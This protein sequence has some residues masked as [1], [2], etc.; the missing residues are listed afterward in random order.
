VAHVVA[1]RSKRTGDAARDERL[2]DLLRRAAPRDALEPIP[3]AYHTRTGRQTLGGAIDSQRGDRNLFLQYLSEHRDYVLRSFPQDVQANMVD[4][5]DSAPQHG[6]TDIT[7]N[8]KSFIHDWVVRH[9]GIRGAVFLPPSQPDYNPTELLFSFIKGVIRRRFPPHVGEVPVAEMVRLIDGAF[10]EVTKTMVEGWLRYGCYRVPGDPEA[11]CGARTRDRCG[12]SAT[13]HV[14]EWWTR[15]LHRWEETN[16]VLDAA[17]RHDL[18]APELATPELRDRF[19][20]AR[21]LLCT[22]FRAVRDVF[23]AAERP[24]AHV[25]VGPRGYQTRVAL[26]SDAA[27]LDMPLRTQDAVHVTYADDT[28]TEHSDN[29]KSAALEELD[30]RVLRLRDD[31]TGF[32]VLHAYTERIQRVSARTRAALDELEELRSERAG[33]LA[34]LARARDGAFAVGAVVSRLVERS[35]AI[36][37]QDVLLDVQECVFQPKLD[38]RHPRT[39]VRV[40]L[41]GESQRREWRLHRADRPNPSRRTLP[42][43]CVLVAAAS[44]VAADDQEYTVRAVDA[45]V[46][47]LTHAA[48][49]ATLEF[50]NRRVIDATLASLADPGTARAAMDEGARAAEAE[51]SRT[52]YR[53]SLPDPRAPARACAVAVIALAAYGHERERMDRILVDV[54]ARYRPTLGDADAR[55]AAALEEAVRVWRRRRAEAGL[56]AAADGERDGSELVARAESL[57]P[58]FVV[59]H[60]RAERRAKVQLR[61][62]ARGEDDE[63]RYPGYPLEEQDGRGGKAYTVGAVAAGGTLTLPVQ[64]VHVRA[65]AVDVRSRREYI[66]G[67]VVFEDESRVE[68]G[69]PLL[70]S[71]RWRVGNV[72]DEEFVRKNAV[73]TGAGDEV[74]ENY[75]NIDLRAYDQV[76]QRI[77]GGISQQNANLLKLARDRHRDRLAKSGERTVAQVRDAVVGTIGE[78]PLRFVG[79]EAARYVRTPDHLLFDPTR[80]SLHAPIHE[81]AKHVLENGRTYRE[82]GVADKEVLHRRVHAEHWFKVPGEGEGHGAPPFDLKQVGEANLYYRTS[83]PPPDSAATCQLV[84]AYEG[85]RVFPAWRAAR[86]PR[87][88]ADLQAQ[89]KMH[90]LTTA[91]QCRRFFVQTAKLLRLDGAVSARILEQSFGPSVDASDRTFSLGKEGSEQV[92]LQRRSGGTVVLMQEQTALLAARGRVRAFLLEHSLLKLCELCDSTVAG[93]GPNFGGLKALF[94]VEPS[95]Y[96]IVLGS[97]RFH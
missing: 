22:R 48:S 31:P 75:A 27:L 93:T 4:A 96:E 79:G 59:S 86:L 53:S 56:G 46:V 80:S 76:Y 11:G 42:R 88:V 62:L 26:G 82:I 69:T 21:A 25:D 67:T 7:K 83:D 57:P 91:L 1:A 55:G 84:Y 3:R 8:T 6:K 89:V 81:A 85:G 66:C 73:K 50:G 32:R 64:V 13:T 70:Q 78:L 68:L 47:R 95:D 94:C 23:A 19:D 72:D 90:A 41:H 58:L 16:Y 37:L 54:M 9:L 63:R 36:P 10:Q 43:A 49:G 92:T 39:R 44:D 38:A 30:R 40:T 51:L 28:R 15:L 34:T 5:F 65:I 17:V 77:F 71:E 29:Y 14:G 87:A 60:M 18:A 35:A 97:I 20:R 45:A 33:L 74:L 24:I 12:Q 2:D 61:L 52:E